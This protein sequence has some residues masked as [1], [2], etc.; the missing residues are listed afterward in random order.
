ME[1]ANAPQVVRASSLLSLSLSLSAA[2]L[3]MIT[4]S[5]AGYTA[6]A[7]ASQRLAVQER[8]ELR[9][10]QSWSAFLQLLGFWLAEGRGHL[11]S[12]SITFSHVQAHECPWL[13]GRLNRVGLDGDDCQWTMEQQGMRLCISHPTW[14]SVFEE[15]FGHPHSS[16]RCGRESPEGEDPSPSQPLTSV[17]IA[18]SGR[19]SRSP[20][21]NPS[22]PASFTSY[23]SHSSSRTPLSIEEED[24]LSS[25]DSIF[26][27]GQCTCDHQSC[28]GT[29]MEEKK[30][31]EETEEDDV[32]SMKWSG[33]PCTID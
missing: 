24:G 18:R 2:P 9:E 29:R 26:P 17:P 23:P 1:G 12:Q 16:P 25:D 21:R 32:K 8:L 13:K 28:G 30:V 4:C 19:R 15:Q 22:S 5:E 20:N 11:S 14:C 7:E 31:D 33:R 6:A 27:S 10:G 3:R